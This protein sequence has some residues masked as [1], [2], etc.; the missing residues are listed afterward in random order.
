MKISLLFIAVV[1]TAAAQDTAGVGSVAG[2]VKASP[3]ARA[4]GVR[5][6]VLTTSRC[7]TTDANGA[8]RITEVRAGAYQL[9][10][11][12]PGQAPILS[13]VVNV[14]A[15]LDGTVNVSLPALDAVQQSIT[16]SDSVIDSLAV[17]QWP[18]AWHHW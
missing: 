4:A 5:V 1:V 17:D 9:E 10:I 2:T 8:F 3:E 18:V 11:S 16:V 6:C 15:G 14:R 7:A 12:A 13:P